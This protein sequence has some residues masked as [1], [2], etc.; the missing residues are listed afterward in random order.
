MKDLVS[1][2]I[3]NWNG[4]KYLDDCLSSIY[5]SSYKNIE[6]ILVDNN[7]K[8]GSISFVRNNFKKTKIIELNDNYGYVGGNIEGIKK[9][10]GKYLLLL[11]NDTRSDPKLITNLVSF[12]KKNKDCGTVQPKIRIL[13]HPEYLDGI[14]SFFTITGFLKHVGHKERENKIELNKTIEA[15][16]I[17]GACM[18]IERKLFNE[19]G[20]FDKRYF[21]YFEETDLCWRVLLKGKKNYYF[22]G[23]LVYHAVGRT[24]SRISLPFIEFHS[25]KNR[26]ATL[27]KN[28]EL[29]NI[30]IVLPIHITLCFGF[31]F[32]YVI[33]GKWKNAKAIINAI[34]WNIESIDETIKL[35]SAIQSKRIV[36]DKLIMHKYKKSFSMD[37]INQMIKF[38]FFKRG[39][40]V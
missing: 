20:G 4:K 11:N 14:G 29:K 5:E 26:I 3:V 22:P 35:R 18:M 40:I 12:Y 34:L 28:L 1:V 10:N 23:A 38:Y 24:T 21:A 27:I 15:F 36:H 17:K 30:V 2:I 13:K 6:V 19:V 16:S 31:I 9:S 32:F 39:K 25:F 37:S 33:S 7:S 8:D